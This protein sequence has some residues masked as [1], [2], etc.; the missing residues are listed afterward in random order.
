MTIASHPTILLRFTLL[1][2]LLASTLQVLA[3]QEPAAHSA[4]Q[5]VEA[6]RGE[7][8]GL[9]AIDTA[10]ADEDAIAALGRRLRLER[11]LREELG[12]LVDAADTAGERPS[13]SPVMSISTLGPCSA[14]AR[15][16][17]SS[18]RGWGTSSAGSSRRNRRTIDR[19]SVRV[20]EASVSI[21]RSASTAASGFTAA[22]ARPAWARIAIADTW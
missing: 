7:L 21:T 22:V 10:A 12:K 16:S 11:E 13:R 5:R 14:A 15:R 9:G 18:M 6:L 17:R 19:I 2:A 3:E 20:R 4:W 1:I 8:A